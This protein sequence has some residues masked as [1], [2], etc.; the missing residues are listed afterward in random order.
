MIKTFTRIVFAI[1]L[2]FSFAF[3]KANATHIMG[4]DISYRCLGGNYYQII[5]TAYRDCS[6]V[7]APTSISVDVTSSNPLCT[8]T[9]PIICDTVGEASAIE[10]SQL[11]TGVNSTCVTSGSIY[12]GVQVYTYVSDSIYLDPSCGT[13]TFIYGDCCRNTSNNLAVNQPGFSVRAT[14]N[15]DSVFCNSAP[16]FTSLPVPYFCLN[17]QVY[18]S[19]GAVDID[20]DSLVYTLVP[21]LDDPPTNLAYSGVFSA[22]Y[23]VTSAGGVFGFD[24]QTGQMTFTPT[25]VGKFV[26]A[27]LV[28]EYRNGVLIGTTMRDIQIVVISC[29]N[30]APLVNNCLTPQN[31]SGG[32]VADCNSLSVCP[33]A[34]VVFTL[35]SRDPDGQ[36]VTVTSNI[37]TSIPGA[38]LT[39]VPVG[40][41]SVL[42][43]FT[44]TPL[45]TDTGFRY[46]TI[47]FEDNAC[48]ITGLQLFT[49]DISVLSGTYAGPDK[50]YCTG[51]DPV[52]VNVRGGSHFSWSTTEGMVSANPDSSDVFL[53]PDST[54]TYIIQSDLIG[55]CKARDTVTV[56]HV[57]TFGTT[58]MSPDDTICLHDATSLTV[59]P[60]PSNQGPFT[61]SW[62]PLS[63][64]IVNPTSS[65]TIVRPTST[66][67]YKVSVVS[68]AGCIIKDSFQVVIQG[69]GPLVSV[70]ASADYVCPGSTIDLT[71]N[72]SALDCGATADPQNPC[73]PNSTFALSDMGSATTAASANTTPYIG[74]WDDGR[75]QYLYRASEL[76]AIGLT[77]GTITDIAFN[78]LN[79]LSTQPYNEYTIKMAC[80]SLNVLPSSF[81]TAGFTT[82]LNPQPYTTT[83]GWNTHT[84]DIP[85]NWDGFSNLIIE[86]CF[87]NS[88]YTQYDNVYYTPSGFNSVLW[89]N[90]DLPTQSGCVALTTPAIGQNRPNT[91]FIMCRA[92]LS[93]YTFTWTGSDGS[94]LPDTSNPSPQIYNAVTYNVIVDDGTCQGSTSIDLH[95][96]TAVLITA[97][98]DTLICNSDTIQLLTQLLHPANLYCVPTYAVSAV[99]YSPI[100]PTGTTT[101]GPSGDDVVSASIIMP[102]S[103]QFFCNA[104]NNYY[105]STNGFV[106]FNT[107]PGSGCCAGQLLP[108]P[109]APNNLVA[110]V[111]EDLNTNSGGYIDRFVSGTAP[112]RVAVIRW[113]N[114]AYYSITGTVNGQIQLYESSNIIEVHVSSVTPTGQTNT[115]GI[116][117]SNGTVGYSPPGYNASGWTVSSP[118]AFRFTPQTA[119]NVITGVLWNPST[120]LSS[121]TILNPLASPDS[122]T[123]YIVAATFTNGCITY[124]TINISLG[125]FP[126][127]LDVVPDSICRGDSAQITFTGNGVLYQWS[128]VESLSSVTVPNPVAFP[129]STTVYQVLATDSAGCRILDNVTVTVRTH[130]PISLGTDRTI[131]PYDSVIL[132]PTGS[133]YTSYSWSTGATSSAITTGSQTLTTQDYWVIVNDG[134]CFYSSDTVSISEFTLSL[135]IVNPSGDT[136]IC[137]GESVELRG[138]PGFVSYQWTNG[139]QTQSITV[140]IPGSYSYIAI[141]TNGCILKSQDTA[142]VIAVQ[143]PAANIIVSDDTLCAGQTTSILSVSPVTGIVYTWNPGDVV[144]DSLV[145]SSEGVYHLVASDNGCKSYDSVRIESTEPPVVDLG[146]DQNLCGCDTSIVLASDVTGTYQWS[147]SETTQSISITTPGNYSLTV[148][149]NNDCTTTDTTDVQ[150]H[151]LIVNAEVSDPASGTVFIGRPAVLNTTTSY[152]STFI[153]SWTPSTY[154]DDTTLQ[155]PHV[156]APQNTTVYF[157]TVY[158]EVNGCS[159]SDSVRLSVVPPGIPPMPN[160][161]S[162]N[163]DGV[164]DTYGPYIPPSMQGIY[165]IG[166]M[167]IYNRWGQ[168]V[169]NGNGFWDGTFN[170]A[171]QPANTYVYYITIDGPDQNDPGVNISYNLT[172]SFALLH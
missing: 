18:Y 154:L 61:Y 138:D 68:S 22:T 115:L 78:V 63:Q 148:T 95:V 126:Y 77:A 162:P 171:F 43:T 129:D 133:P 106:A 47:Q 33:G 1:S 163:G 99:P 102:F 8:P 60:Q 146:E 118:I 44:W 9:T 124:D 75:V 16:S 82:V 94:T 149:D 27:V 108:N 19:H 7:S 150:I 109:T 98:A 85:Y 35:G 136:A 17:Q 141:D 164:N 92:P 130:V 51:G 58:I 73:L 170:G 156:T 145:V 103:F 20:G 88:T 135:I 70:Y 86:V 172:G 36:P 100:F 12:P 139:A 59:T 153:F 93:N 121:D 39:S 110:M 90:A 14:L 155:T 96:D 122:N 101:A 34:T 131:C 114:V 80:T 134:H 25:Q 167:R 161:F 29:S 157:V 50:F 55:S 45:G 31:V 125:T 37:A 66:T 26:V 111:W 15:S 4:S 52:F 165:T 117:N 76:Q 120:G 46:F 21:P 166:Q 128:P 160:A 144:N 79:K 10:V 87:N 91:R 147:T 105:I 104:V 67:M 40:V 23:P 119:G 127:T 32:I 74:F 41:D 11:C 64:G 151:C 28:S 97:G 54:T 48:P 62:T 71:M 3:E 6:G 89:D 65:T 158:D 112:N 113:N 13:Y 72:V 116:E 30:T 69:V 137:I 140:I 38:T 56:F 159:A 169:Y 152:G 84:L 81:V 83:T 5:V 142:N 53:A 57:T 107:Q 24:Q 132:S 2:A 49:Y 123:T 42:V 143:H 168:M